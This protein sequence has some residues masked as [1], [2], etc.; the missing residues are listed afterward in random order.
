MQDFDGDGRPDIFFG[1]IGDRTVLYQNG[2]S[3]PGAFEFGSSRLISTDRFVFSAVAGDIDNDGDVDI[4]A[5]M[6]GNEIPA[7]DALWENQGDGQFI[8]IAGSDDLAIA[9]SWLVDEPSPSMSAGARMVDVNLDGRLD[10]WVDTYF[11][12]VDAPPQLNSWSPRY[13]NRLLLQQTDGGFDEIAFDGSADNGAT[14]FSSWIDIDND[15]DW[16]LYENNFRGENRLWRNLL[17]ESGERGFEDVTAE[18][19]IGD[20]RLER[21]LGSFVT[22]VA[23]L[24]NDGWLDLVVATREQISLGDTHRI[25]LN[26][27]GTGFVD[28]SEDSGIADL[29]EMAQG[30]GVMGFQVGDLTA[31][32]LPDIFVGRGGPSDGYGNRLFIAS[33]LKEVE[34]V[35]AGVIWV[36]VFEDRTELIDFAPEENLVQVYPPYP[37]RTHGTCFADLDNDGYVEMFVGNGGRGLD[38]NNVREPNRLFQFTLTP[39][40]KNLIVTLVG[41]GA[42]VNRSAIGTRVR[43]GVEDNDGR[44]WD[45]HGVKLGSNGFS[46]DLGPDV[47][48]G[49][50]FATHIHEVEVTWTDGSVQYVLHPEPGDH[51]TV[52]HSG[53]KRGKQ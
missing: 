33:H 17:N 18:M 11:P 45:V 48:V 35:V 50:G 21:P 23:D 14:Q 38:G 16:D 19:N 6:G 20:T 10:I 52:V 41:D 28:V 7:R 32:G 22:A 13:E 26:V 25:F 2:T 12:I 37:Y 1:A 39:A 9:N 53:D 46:A 8:D 27:S 15:G 42:L 47:V 3:V 36:P 34:H 49:V 24:N 4:F 43:V 30:K 51:I 5:A 40:P 29:F 44:R 31:D